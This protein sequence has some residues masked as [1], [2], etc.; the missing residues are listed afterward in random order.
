MSSTLLAVEK[1]SKVPITTEVAEEF[2]LFRGRTRITAVAVL[3]APSE[4]ITSATVVR[5]KLAAAWPAGRLEEADESRD[6][7]R[8]SNLIPELER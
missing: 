8:T 2:N 1:F 3:L 5:E 4:S 7:E 6:E